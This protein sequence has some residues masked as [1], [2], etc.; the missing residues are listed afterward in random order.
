MIAFLKQVP[1]DKSVNKSLGNKKSVGKALRAEG[2][3]ESQQPAPPWHDGFLAML[4]A[5][6][7]RASY[8]FRR[9]DLQS[10]EEAINEVIASS[11]VAYVALWECGKVALAFPTVLAEYA[12]AQFRAGRRVGTRANSG[13]VFAEAAQQRYHFTVESLDQSDREP[14]DWMEATIEDTHTSV[15]EQA[16]FRID[17]PAW[18]GTHAP[19]KRRIAKTL[20]LGYS[21]R[22]AAARF[23]ISSARISQLRREFDDSWTAFHEKDATAEVAA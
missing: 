6:R 4:P 15:P 19:R 22:E 3:P 7:Y 20:A 1:A 13:D 5:I 12:A 23:Q 17:F 11:L 16:A 18:L 14:G 9:L 2:V 10:R 21:T 8:L